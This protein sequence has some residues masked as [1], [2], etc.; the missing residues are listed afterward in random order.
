MSST[1]VEVIAIVLADVAAD[2]IQFFKQKSRSMLDFFFLLQLDIFTNLYDSFHIFYLSNIGFHA[3]FQHYLSYIPSSSCSNGVAPST[4][5][6][7]A[8]K[9]PFP[10]LNHF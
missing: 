9:W 3:C 10:P 4:N 2:L 8:N 1:Y 6:V 5:P 7:V